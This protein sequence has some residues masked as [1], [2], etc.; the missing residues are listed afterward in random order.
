MV[1]G[2]FIIYKVSTAGELPSNWPGGTGFSPVASSVGKLITYGKTE[3]Q[4]ANTTSKVVVQR[5]E[6][7][8]NEKQIE[9]IAPFDDWHALG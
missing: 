6:D 2:A 8:A 3:G 7:G 1:S 5:P 9:M 4:G